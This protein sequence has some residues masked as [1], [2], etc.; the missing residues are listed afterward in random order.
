MLRRNRGASTAP[1]HLHQAIVAAHFAYE[2]LGV[3]ETAVFRDSSEFNKLLDQQFSNTFNQLG[4]SVIY[5]GS[6]VPGQPDVATLLADAANSAPELIYLALFEPEGNLVLNRLAESSSLNR[7]IVLGADSLSSADFAE[8]IGE[9]PAEIYVT[10]PALSGTA[11]D[12]FQA[13]W[14]SRYETLPTSPA[15]AYAYDA[16]Q[17]LLT[18][19]EEVAVMGQ[20]GALIVG[21]GALRQRLA[22]SEAAGLTGTLRCTASGDCF[23]TR[24]GVY[25]L[26][27]AVRND[28]FW[29]PPLIWQYE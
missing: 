26:D 28:A 15:P 2:Q 7:A 11:Y 17:L 3:R 8:Q 6:V 25:E 12:S 9:L 10:G 23:A 4:G 18:A 27:T 21:R 24:Y 14:L 29:P 13:V 20:N 19:I 5:Q 1:N 22:A 16:T